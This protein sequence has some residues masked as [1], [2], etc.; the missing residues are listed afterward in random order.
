MRRAI[1]QEDRERLER[2]LEAYLRRCFASQS[3][4]RAGEFAASLSKSSSYLAREF[5]RILGQS[6]LRAL[7]SRQVTHAEHLLRTTSRSTRDIALA[8]AFGT[9]ATFYRVFRTLRG[10]TPREYRKRF[11][12]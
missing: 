10:M 7:R 5:P 6:V 2:L 4:A 9:Q 1:V 3:A 12:K 8:A 11:T